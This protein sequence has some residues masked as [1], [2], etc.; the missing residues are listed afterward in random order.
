MFTGNQLKIIER[1]KVINAGNTMVTEYI[2]TDPEHWV[3]EWRHIKFRDRM[4]RADVR[5]ATCLSADNDLLPGM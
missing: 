4:L 5:E 1:I 3:G 2:M